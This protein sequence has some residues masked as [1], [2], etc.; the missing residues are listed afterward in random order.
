MLGLEARRVQVR[1]GEFIS[2]MISAMIS[3]ITSRRIYLGDDLRDHISAIHL[4]EFISAII[5]AITRR[6]VKS[7]GDV[8]RHLRSTGIH[9]GTIFLATDNGTVR[10][11]LPN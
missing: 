6:Y 2:A 5:P 10:T 11:Y 3:A 1:L 4:G 7:F 9:S 8:V